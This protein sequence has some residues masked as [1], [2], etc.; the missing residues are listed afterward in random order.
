MRQGAVIR[1]W[2]SVAKVI[3]KLLCCIQGWWTSAATLESLTPH[4]LAP[5]S[6]TKA[7]KHKRVSV[8]TP[9]R[10]LSRQQKLF[11]P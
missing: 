1:K 2:M 6:P 3:G 8:N 5:S 11:E 10:V 7:H 9:R 4:S